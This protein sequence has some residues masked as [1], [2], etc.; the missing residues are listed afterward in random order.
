MITRLKQTLVDHAPFI[1]NMIN[2]TGAQT[3]KLGICLP[4]GL[5]TAI[6]DQLSTTDLDLDAIQSFV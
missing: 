4:R 6:R 3:C 1:G 5:S 2:C